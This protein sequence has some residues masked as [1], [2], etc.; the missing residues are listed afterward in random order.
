MKQTEIIIPEKLIVPMNINGIKGR[1]LTLPATGSVKQNILLIYGHHSSIE[2]MY[3]LARSLTEYGTIT[4]PDIPGF[5]G[6]DSFYS[7]GET[8]SID[9]MADYLATFIKL[10]YKKRSF[11]VC[12][13]SYGSLIVTRMMQKYPDIA[14]QVSMNISLVGFSNKEDF[15]F[16]PRTYKIL[17]NGSRLL[18]H[19]IPSFF[20]KHVVFSKP[21]I[22][23]TY[24]LT[25]KSHVKMK[26]ATKEERNR[27]IRFEVYL[28]QCNDARTYFATS[29]SFL[30][31]DLT[32]IPIPTKVY[33]IH[34]TG[35]QYFRK[36]TV[37][38]NLAK[39]YTKV[40]IYTVN[41]PN[42]APTVISDQEEAGKI[43]PT[44]LKKLLLQNAK[45]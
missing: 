9:R 4:M 35:D 43:I 38:K 32:T 42:H 21:L 36:E 16:S 25:A 40:I 39:I 3:S 13:M 44:K 22:T 10:Q 29:A 17:Y 27:R 45:P 5:G 30:N 14:K 19:P 33:H 18:S 12:G 28:W 20:A 41:L 23:L 37:V 6:M 2:R 1:V 31:I 26:D 24:R 15:S 8:P 7:I 11:V 34:V